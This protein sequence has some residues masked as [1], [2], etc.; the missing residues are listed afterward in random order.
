MWSTKQLKSWETLQGTTTSMINPP[1][2]SSLSS[3]LVA[4]ELQVRLGVLCMWSDQVKPL[5]AGDCS[6]VR[7]PL[8]QGT[9][10]KPGGPHYVLRWT[11]PQVVKQTHVPLTDWKYPYMGWEGPAGP[12]RALAPSISWFSIHPQHLHIDSCETKRVSPP[13]LCLCTEPGPEC[14]WAGSGLELPRDGPRRWL[15]ICYLTFGC[16]FLNYTKSSELLSNDV[17]SQRQ[18]NDV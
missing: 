8:H 11:S 2:P 7:F 6:T 1:A 18:T 3:H 10:D 4:P 9:N 13:S 12:I 17:I 16:W 15:H 5:T 14:I